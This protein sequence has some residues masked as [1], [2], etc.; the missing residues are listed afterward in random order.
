MV[1]SGDPEQAGVVGEESQTRRVSQS[2]FRGGG[3][4]G[5]M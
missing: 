4:L 5:S 1:S 2:A 3:S